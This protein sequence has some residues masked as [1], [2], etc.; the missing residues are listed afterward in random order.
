MGID[1][2]SGILIGFVLSAAFWFLTA[3]WLVARLK[4][5]DYIEEVENP[6]GSLRYRIFLANAGHRDAI[7]VNVGCSMY[8]IGWAGDPADMVATITI[9]VSNSDIDLMAGRSWTRATLKFKR[10]IDF[11][12]TRFI[13]LDIGKISDYQKSK[14]DRVHPVLRE[15]LEDG[16]LTLRELMLNGHNSFIAV[17][18]FAYDR[19]SGARSVTAYA[20]F[21]PDAIRRLQRST[22]SESQYVIRR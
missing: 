2:W 6:N 13:Y 20:E 10:M 16:R 7:N 22:P 15:Q 17:V 5:S 9:P 8:S 14:L 21:Q 4:I 11:V 19:F 3:K 1:F 18:V 12:G